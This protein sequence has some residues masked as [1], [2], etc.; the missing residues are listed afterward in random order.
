MAE[1]EKEIKSDEWDIII[2]DEVGVAIEMDIVDV[3]DV[4]RL[5]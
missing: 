4:L 1:A 5:F 3:E 2:L